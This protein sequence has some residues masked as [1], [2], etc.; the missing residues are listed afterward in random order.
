MREKLTEKKKKT[1]N[2]ELE[3]TSHGFWKPTD[4][5]SRP[6]RFDENQLYKVKK[7]RSSIKLNTSISEPAI[8]FQCYS[9]FLTTLNSGSSF[10]TNEDCSDQD[11]NF[12]EM[13]LGDITVI[14][15]SLFQRSVN[16]QFCYVVPGLYISLQ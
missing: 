13:N 2:P 16:K 11:F 1:K 15:S 9:V 5:Y 3:F 4:H 6:R 8:I 7:L 10:N 12:R 14:E